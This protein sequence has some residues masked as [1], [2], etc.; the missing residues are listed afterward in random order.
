MRSIT[1]RSLG[2][3][4]NA[5]ASAYDLAI[6]QITVSRARTLAQK[7]TLYAAIAANLAQTPG[8]RP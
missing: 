6:I 3:H 2:D 7:R 1:P 5:A 8:M 4:R